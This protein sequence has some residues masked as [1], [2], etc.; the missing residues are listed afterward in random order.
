M[1][2][3]LSAPDQE[4]VEDCEVCCRPITVSYTS[5][6]GEVADFSARADGE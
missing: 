5:G 3:D 4:Y 1:V 2:L 6:Q